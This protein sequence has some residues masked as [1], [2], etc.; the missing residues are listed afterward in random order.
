M[1]LL[2]PT[3]A[4]EVGEKRVTWAELFFDLVFVFA[5]TQ[6]S[7]LLHADHSAAGMF[8]ALVLFVPMYWAWVGTSINA[9]L[10]D[11][12]NPLDRIAIF[13]IALLSLFLAMA[14]PD[15]YGSRGLLFGASYLA[16]R[17]VL[18]GLFFHGRRWSLHPFAV[19]A[20]TAGPLILL[21]GLVHGHA[22]VAL[23]AVA[24]LCDLAIPTLLRARV[25]STRFHAAHLP[26][27]Y[28]IL[29]LIALGESIV[30]I[31]A[32]VARSPELTAGMVGAVTAA[33]VLA[34]G[35][36]WVYF[37][38][39]TDAIRHALEVAPVQSVIVRHVLSWAHLAFVGGIIAMA[40]GIGEVLL[41][42][43][44]P[45]APEFAGL[46]Y[47]GVALYFATFNY[48]RWQMFRVWSP[49][50]TAGA[51]ATVVLAPLATVIPALA[52]LALLAAVAVAVNVWEHRRFL[53][54][55]VR[56]HGGP[57]DR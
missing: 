39:A 33:F 23:W 51:V 30:A 27:R 45:L 5:V 34:C 48:T 53:A 10:R 41:H 22:R 32:P 26:E 54:A 36:G 16:I 3:T 6:V 37:G 12:D 20:G 28:G 29:V 42:P 11:V 38:F 24:G 43:G 35:L 13:T 1:T 7:A 44:E 56:G 55:T 52:A 50:R 25:A 15:A 9:N 17:L 21:G 31:G 49:T 4:G 47:G 40:A 8:R 18:A 46:M 57:G 2:P 14:T 19:S